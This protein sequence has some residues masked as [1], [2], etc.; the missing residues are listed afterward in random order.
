M[1]MMMMCMSGI[2]RTPVYWRVSRSRYGNTHWSPFSDLTVEQRNDIERDNGYWYPYL[3][4]FFLKE[5]WMPRKVLVE[6]K[7]GVMAAGER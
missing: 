1:M 7:E 3:G 2:S 4:R 5:R 6:M